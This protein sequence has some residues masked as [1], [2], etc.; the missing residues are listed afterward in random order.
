VDAEETLRRVPLFAE[1]QKKQLRSLA[2]WTSTRNFNE[3]QVIVSEGQ[4]GL[5]LYIIESGRVKVTQKT[6]TGE[7]EIRQMGPGESFGE[8]ALLDNSPRGATVS[9]AEPT[10]CVLLDKVQFLAELRTYPEIALSI[11]PVLV[12][13]LR[14]ADARIA[15]LS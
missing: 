5:G 7:R 11:I 15:Q 14:E 3:G 13:W 6:A 1:L 4:S 9:A 8:L 12:H 2:K 10:T